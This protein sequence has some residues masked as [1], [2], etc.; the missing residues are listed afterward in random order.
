MLHNAGRHTAWSDKHAAYEILN[1]PSGNGIDDLFTAEITA[2]A[3][4][5]DGTPAAGGGDYTVDNQRTMPYDSYKVQAVLNEIDGYDHSR[6]T[7]PGTPALFGMNFQ[8]VSTAQKLPVS[9]GLNGGYLPGTD[10]PGAPGQP[11]A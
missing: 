7:Q 5:P 3:Q 1:G 4:N 2:D 11:R 8:T 10:T 9:N 6:T